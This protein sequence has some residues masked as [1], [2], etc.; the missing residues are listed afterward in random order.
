MIPKP[1]ED[2]IHELSVAMM[3]EGNLDFAAIWGRIREAHEAAVAEEREA[4]AKA[5]WD[6][7]EKRKGMAKATS[8]V[9][10][11]LLREIESSTFRWAAQLVEG[12]GSR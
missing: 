6:E 12:R 10:D 11:G 8:T 9:N 1:L 4:C 5:L 3:E 7:S 2:A